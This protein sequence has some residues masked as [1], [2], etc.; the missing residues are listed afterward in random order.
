MRSPK[1]KLT[2]SLAFLLLFAVGSFAQSLVVK[3][4]VADAS[5]NPLPGAV[6][7]VRG[8]SN[9]A[10]STLDGKFEIEGVGVKSELEVSY[11]G[12]I[13]QVIPVNGRVDIN[14]VMQEDKTV[15]EEV[16]VVGYGVQ[17]VGTVTGSVS[18]IK[19]DKLTMAPVGNVN[20]ALAGRMPGHM[21]VLLCEVD[22]PYDKLLS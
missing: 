12:F 6:V 5:G 14:I 1:A 3:G 15:L 16:V 21:N 9:A 2:L 4:T 13:S 22:V 19:S 17:K 18:Q 7:V 20:N 10:I 11:V 8:T